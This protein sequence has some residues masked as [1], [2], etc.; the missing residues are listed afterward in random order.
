LARISLIFANAARAWSGS[1][2]PE[3]SFAAVSSV[4]PGP[5]DLC[6]CEGFLDGVSIKRKKVPCDSSLVKR[7]W[8]AGGILGESRS[9]IFPEK[10]TSS[11]NY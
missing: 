9:L 2:T 6:P 8:D 7:G 4:A 1:E 5:G 11:G 3:A 10:V